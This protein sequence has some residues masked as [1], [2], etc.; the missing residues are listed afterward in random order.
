MSGRGLLAGARGAWGPSTQAGH[1]RHLARRRIRSGRRQ[2]AQQELRGVVGERR[3][4]RAVEVEDGVGAVPTQL[5]DVVVVARHRG[6]PAREARRLQPGKRD[7]VRLVERHREHRDAHAAGTLDAV[8]ELQVGGVGT[9]RVEAALVQLGDP[10]LV[11]LDPDDPE[12]VLVAKP[13]VGGRADPA[14][15]EH[16][17]VGRIGAA[18][19]TRLRD[20]YGLRVVGVEHDEL[21]IAELHERGFDTFRADAT[22]LE[23]WNRVERAGS[24]RVAVLA[25]PLHKA[26]LIALARLKAAGF[27]GRVAAV[28]RYDDDVAELRRHGAD[29]V[30]HLYGSAGAALADHAAEFLL[31]EL[32]SPGPDPTPR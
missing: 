23:F 26:N 10:Q 1:L 27:T 22:D 32:P 29:A 17:G 21:R 5:G 18:T 7:E 4:G 28:A 25:M 13:G 11:V 16:H 9:E 12:P 15:P 14:E 30:F 3:A 2:L 31:G 6:D 19:Y 24:V 20:E 8:P